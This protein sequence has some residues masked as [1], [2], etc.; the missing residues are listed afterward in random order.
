MDATTRFVADITVAL[1]AG[2]AAGAAARALRITPIVGY[3]LAGI[4]IGPFT[5]GYVAHSSSLSGLA[6][7]GLIFLL[8][9]LGLGFT[10]RDLTEAGVRAIIC[11]IAAM[12]AGAVV[13]WL[14][15][16]RFGAVHPIT[17]ALAFTVSSTAV[18][19]AVLQVLSLLDKPAGRVAVS[20]LIVQD[21]IAVLILVVISTPANALT[22]TGVLIPLFRAAVFV[23]VALVLGAT[24]LHRLF[25]TALHRAG[26][27]LLVVI[28]SAVAL[29]AAWLGHLA[30][31]T[32]EFG[33]FVA[34]AVTSE[35]AGSLMVQNVV[36]PFRELFVM[37]FFVSM[38][39]LVDISSVLANWKAIV[40]VAVVAIVVRVVLWSAAARFLK[41]SNAGA[42]ALGIALLPMGEFNIVLGN[43][44]FAAGR[45]N[46]SEM[47]LLV[48]VGMIA[49]LA[50]ALAASFGGKRLLRLDRAPQAARDGVIAA[51]VVILG[52]GRVGQTV[53]QMLEQ[54]GIHVAIVEHDAALVR[55]AQ[56]AGLLAL[57]ADAGDPHTLAQVTSSTTRVVLTSIPDSSVNAAIA[58]WLAAQ[59]SAAIVARA[60][61]AEDV[62]A[63]LEAG[64][65]SAL[66]PEVE[67]ARAFG[68]AVLEAL[69]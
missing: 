57:F 8:F 51:S 40:L 45:L 55:K 56:D 58:R 53:A 46:R 31:L 59:S 48:G 10:P 39:T 67:G 62:T 42:V 43:A 66:V 34:G 20:L 21:L 29:A 30:G 19:V 64:A 35:A 65:R 24:I 54:R 44:S 49:V 69:V 50:S 27:D 14:V 6:E 37:L 11:N 9:S 33:A 16:A 47:A 13:V 12:A 63:L 7:I 28:F 18:G 38:G 15:L 60:G 22:V 17:L 61:R 41:L 2:G 36:R 23:L 3:L 25:N 52:Y 26:T 5:P 1:I 68:V 32:F 4:I